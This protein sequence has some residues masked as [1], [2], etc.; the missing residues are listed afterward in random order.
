MEQAFADIKKTFDAK[1]FKYEVLIAFWLSIH[2]QRLP[3]AQ[4]LYSL[5][6]IIEKILINLRKHGQ[7]YLE[8][9]RQRKLKQQKSKLLN[10]F[11]TPKEEDI[12]F[13]SGKR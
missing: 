11:Q 7:E 12:G 5:D 4:H 2:L 6:P 9:A 10:A 1:G 13:T 3:T 8:Q